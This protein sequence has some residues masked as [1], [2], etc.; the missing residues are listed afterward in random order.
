MIVVKWAWE[1]YDKATILPLRVWWDIVW[2]YKLIEPVERAIG[3]KI[4]LDYF[5]QLYY[6]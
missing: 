1:E 5:L 3:T 2:H 4:P 6:N